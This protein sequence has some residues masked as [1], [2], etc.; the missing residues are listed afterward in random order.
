[1]Q[2]YIIIPRLWATSGRAYE[3]RSGSD[4][5]C[6]AES[7]AIIDAAFDHLARS[8]TQA[9]LLAGDLTNDG[10]MVCH[11]EL[12]EKLYALAEKKPVYLITNTHDWC[13]D[14]NPL[15]FCRGAELGKPSSARC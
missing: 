8:D 9:V 3:L 1:M 14:G 11:R 7:G 4:Q 15:V 10:E 6:R 13:C 2:I 5:K 12:R